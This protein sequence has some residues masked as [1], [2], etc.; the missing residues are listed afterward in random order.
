MPGFGGG[1]MN[2]VLQPKL[3]KSRDQALQLGF[4]GYGRFKKDYEYALAQQQPYADYGTETL[5]QFEQW[6]AN[7]TFSDPSY[8]WRFDE[9]QRAVE[10]SAAAKGGQLS[11][12]ALRAIADYGQGAASQEYG[13]EFNRWLQRLGIGM[14]GANNM[15]N[16]YGQRGTQTLNAAI[17]GGQ[18]WFNNNLQSAAEIRQAEQGLN[19][20]LQSWIPS[21]YGG[22]G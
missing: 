14:T 8:N 2:Y 16:L 5:N 20:I 11:G 21:S 18:N 1:A 3:E 4:K 17:G 12:N 9:G 13:N 6:T 19:N 22:G 7:P 10:N 15:S